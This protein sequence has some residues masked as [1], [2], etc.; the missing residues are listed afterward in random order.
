MGDSSQL[1]SR[2]MV[3]ED[4]GRTPIMNQGWLSGKDG[5]MADRRESRL[6]WSNANT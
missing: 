6:S 1:A 3:G 4:G 5:G 2:A